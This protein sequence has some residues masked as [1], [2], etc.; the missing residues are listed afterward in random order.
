MGKESSHFVSAPC[1][2]AESCR[3]GRIICIQKGALGYSTREN[4]ELREV[5]LLPE[6]T[7]NKRMI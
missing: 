3:S 5:S 7:N 1:N 2:L 6:A 4:Q